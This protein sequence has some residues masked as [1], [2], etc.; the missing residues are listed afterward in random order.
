[1]DGKPQVFLSR[2][3]RSPQHTGTP[4]M[5]RTSKDAPA[6]PESQP[7]R[8]M[9][10]ASMRATNMTRMMPGYT[11]ISLP[12]PPISVI[13]GPMVQKRAPLV[14]DVKGY[15]RNIEPFFMQIMKDEEM[16][17]SKENANLILDAVI[18]QLTKVLQGAAQESRRR[19][20]YYAKPITEREITA[21]PMISHHFLTVEQYYSNF[22]RR[23]H[24][25]PTD[26]YE[27]Y[28]HTEGLDPSKMNIFTQEGTTEGQEQRLQMIKM[29]QLL[30]NRGIMTK[31]VAKEP[32]QQNYSAEMDSYLTRAK[33]QGIP[34]PTPA[35]NPKTAEIFG[36]KEA[37]ERRLS[38]RE[39]TVPD[40]FAF[41]N[42]CCR[43]VR[44]QVPYLMLSRLNR[45]EDEE[46]R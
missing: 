37:E 31:A 20:N 16:N 28:Y 29:F 41:M 3:K 7:Q 38:T 11:E 2:T 21:S 1:M 42:Q 8:V 9:D 18:A 13:S 10:F 36:G 39:I 44:Q 45:F 17:I 19:T 14:Q 4:L 43:S 27:P 34:K 35:F 33:N 30:T 23:K 26:D 6:N 46:L 32:D 25:Q 12:F 15:L 5:I 22:M 40:I 24:L